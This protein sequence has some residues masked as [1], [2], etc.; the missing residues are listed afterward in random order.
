[1]KSRQLFLPLTYTPN[2]KRDLFRTKTKFIFHTAVNATLTHLSRL[3][4][5]GAI[6]TVNMYPAPYVAAILSVKQEL[7]PTSN[8]LMLRGFLDG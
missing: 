4:L 2:Q 8:Q 5:K 7:I 3:L 6:L 1:M